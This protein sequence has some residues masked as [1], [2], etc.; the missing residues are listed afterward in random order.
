[1]NPIFKVVLDMLHLGADREKQEQARRAAAASAS[2]SSP[3]STSTTI[4]SN[5]S[6][7]MLAPS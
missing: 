5:C 3:Y 6:Q 4:S 1:M 7:S 2:G